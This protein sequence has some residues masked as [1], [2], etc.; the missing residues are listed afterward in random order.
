[1]R[2]AKP[3]ESRRRPSWPTV[4][5]VIVLVLVALAMLWT[6]TMDYRDALAGIL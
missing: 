6:S 2:T 5:M 4:Y 1:M 3:K